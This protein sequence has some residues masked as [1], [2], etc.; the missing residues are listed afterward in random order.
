MVMPAPGTTAPEESFTTPRMVPVFCCAIAVTA[1][2]I[3]QI[4]KKPKPNLHRMSSSSF[5]SAFSNGDAGLCTQN[6]RC[7]AVA[8][9]AAVYEDLNELRGCVI[10]LLASPQG[11]EYARFK[12]VHILLPMTAD[13]RAIF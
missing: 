10:P 11:G 1:A 7:H 2:A 3:Q 13:D 5:S 4:V 6:E 12:F 8:T 9:V